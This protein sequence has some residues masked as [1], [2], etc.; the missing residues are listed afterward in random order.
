MHE[1]MIWP[2]TVSRFDISLQNFKKPLD[3]FW[4]QLNTKKK[5][6]SEEQLVMILAVKRKVWAIF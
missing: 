3:I 1:T 5:K 4:P 6:R 2:T